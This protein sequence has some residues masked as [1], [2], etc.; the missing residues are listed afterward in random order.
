M[1][2]RPQ[3]SIWVGP[4]AKIIFP[5][6]GE[7][8]RTLRWST[9]TE[10]VV[11]LEAPQSADALPMIISIGS[12]RPPFLRRLRDLAEHLSYSRTM[13]REDPTVRSASAPCARCSSL[14][15]S[16]MSLFDS[17][18]G[19]GRA[20]KYRNQ[21]GLGYIVVVSQS[22]RSAITPQ[23]RYTSN[24]NVRSTPFW[25]IQAPNIRARRDTLEP[26]D[27]FPKSALLRAYALVGFPPFLVILIA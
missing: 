11:I 18:S 23:V 20:G 9:R 1:S 10:T 15:S 8:P 5:T 17:G 27:V 19:H 12:E 25:V 21:F 7:S 16:G 3:V 14:R 6:V 22:Q 26:H 24:E 2:C 4:C 13:P